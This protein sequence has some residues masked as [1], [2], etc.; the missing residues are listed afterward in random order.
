[1]VKGASCEQDYGVSFRYGEDSSRGRSVD[2]SNASSSLISLQRLRLAFTTLD[3]DMD[4][5]ILYCPQVC[6]TNS[7]ES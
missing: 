1:V 6:I 2:L 5:F 3:R 4:L 7:F